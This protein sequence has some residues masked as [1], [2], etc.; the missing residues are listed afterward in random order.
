MNWRR[1]AAPRLPPQSLAGITARLPAYPGS[2]LFA[3]MLN[4]TLAA[5][6]PADVRAALEA[7]P[8]RLRISNLSIAFDVCWRGRGFVPLRPASQPHLAIAASLN[9]LWLM[10]R[11]LE[12]PDSLFFS[13]RLLLEGDTELGLIFKNCLDAFDLGAFDLFLQRIALLRPQPAPTHKDTP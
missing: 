12:D 6:L 13:R 11:R 1:H 2:W 7:R 3:R 8:V 9:D 5:Q 4:A 10:A